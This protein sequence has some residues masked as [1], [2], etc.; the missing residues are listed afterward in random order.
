MKKGIVCSICK[1]KLVPSQEDLRLG[2]CGEK[3]SRH[4]LRCGWCGGTLSQRY[5]YILKKNP[6]FDWFVPPRIEELFGRDARSLHC[7]DCHRAYPSKRNLLWYLFWEL[8]VIW[9]RIKE[10]TDQARQKYHLAWS[11]KT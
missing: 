6:F 7:F 11:S 1:T 5:A 2:A 8:K 10:I 3:T 4:V 9:W